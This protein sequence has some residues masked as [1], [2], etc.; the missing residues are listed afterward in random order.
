MYDTTMNNVKGQNKWVGVTLITSCQRPRRQRPGISR[1][2]LG[3]DGLVDASSTVHT[4]RRKW[5]ALVLGAD[6]WEVSRRIM[7]K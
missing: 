6:V 4:K 5:G 2:A 1:F 7:R 3:P